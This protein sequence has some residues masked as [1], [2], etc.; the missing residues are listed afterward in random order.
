MLE[1]WQNL[2]RIDI[3]LHKNILKIL[4]GNKTMMQFIKKTTQTANNDIYA[5]SGSTL[6][7]GINARIKAGI[8]RTKNIVHHPNACL[9]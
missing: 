5:N 9:R 7:Q 3:F 8:K 6:I 1:V 2:S 4:R